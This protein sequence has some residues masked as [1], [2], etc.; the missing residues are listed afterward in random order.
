MQHGLGKPALL[1]IGGVFCK[2]HMIQRIKCQVAK[3]A[4]GW[5]KEKLSST[6]STD[7][8]SSSGDNSLQG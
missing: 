2:A 7:M 8:L 4:N 1:A 6:L 3:V 5:H